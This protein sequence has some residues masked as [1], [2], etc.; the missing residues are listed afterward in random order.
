MVLLHGG[1]ELA[2]LLPSPHFHSQLFADVQRRERPLGALAIEIDTTETKV[3]R[4]GFTS[5]QA[6]PKT[7]ETNFMKKTLLT[8]IVLALATLTAFAADHKGVVVTNGGRTAIATVHGKST[9]K[10][11]PSSD[12]T[13][14]YSNLGGHYPDGV[15][16]CCEG[17]TISGPDSA[18]GAEYWAAVA[19]TPSTSTTVTRVKV[20]V[21][22][23][24]GQTDFVLSLNEDASGIPG[25]ALKTWKVSNLT[26][27]F[28]DC[29]AVE[30]KFA[31]V[32]VTAGTQ[33]WVVVS[34]ESNSTL[35]AAWNTDDTRQLSSDAIPEA[36]YSNGTWNAY[37]GYPGLAFEV[38]GQ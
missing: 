20:A 8:L 18:L 28:G 1:T 10:Y 9:T 13:V 22:Y 2:V 12:T 33:Y 7:E 29:C 15:Y 34:T 3:P 25:K 27:D 5:A 38:V 35:F 23:V 30:A 11:V 16:W 36:S 37:S 32:P 24:E 17:A 21:G 6:K 26:N 14:I 31:S 4:S 19:F